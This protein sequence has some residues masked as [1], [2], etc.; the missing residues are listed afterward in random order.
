MPGDLI[1]SAR[2][3]FRSGG[4]TAGDK[5]VENG[6][7][8]GQVRM[9]DLDRSDAFEDFIPGRGIVV[10]GVH[11]GVSS[12]F[13]PSMNAAMHYVLA[14]SGP[15]WK[16][17]TGSDVRDML[18][19]SFLTESVRSG[20]VAITRIGH[21]LIAPGVALTASPDSIDTVL[22]SLP[23]MPSIGPDLISRSMAL[24]RYWPWH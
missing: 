19:G 14:F 23:S 16:L 6:Q 22:E 17:R 18:L 10:G 3:V 15:F 9:V 4:L 12:E 2:V 20:S 1:S 8:E 21:E 11:S 13:G 24:A 7:F 5:S